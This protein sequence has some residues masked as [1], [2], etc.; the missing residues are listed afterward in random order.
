[1]YRQIL[2]LVGA[3]LAVAPIGAADLPADAA[4]DTNAPNRTLVP[5]VVPNSGRLE[6]LPHDRDLTAWVTLSHLDKR[7]SVRPRKST[8]SLPL[9]GDV[10]RGREIAVSPQRGNCVACHK[11][12]GD[13]W[14]GTVGN[15]LLRY[16][17][18]EYTADRIYQQIYDPRIFNP[19][20]VMP[21]FGSHN[22]LAEQD[23]RDLVAYL[24]SI[25]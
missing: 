22:L 13:D 4:I 24:Q 16:K 25:E 2:I 11:L 18:Y 12:P 3:W 20:S 14:P 1:M 21:P 23:I 17:H 9:A 6:W 5:K 19:S 10:Q 15:S 8:L 7:A